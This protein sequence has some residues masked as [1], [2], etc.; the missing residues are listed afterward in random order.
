MKRM[1]S[2]LLA[3]LLVAVLAIP[4]FAAGNPGDLPY[5]VDNAGIL[6][7]DEE[8][9]LEKKAQS[10]S[11]KYACDVLILTVDSLGNSTPTAFA[12]DYF[13]YNGYGVGGDRSGIVLVLSMEERKCTLS[14]RGFA[15]DAFTDYGQD[16]MWDQILPEFGDDDYY[17]G[18]EVYLQLSDELLSQARAGEPLDVDTDSGVGGFAYVLCVIVGFLL[19]LIPMSVLKKQVKNVDSKFGA[20][21]YVT[22]EGL[23]LSQKTDRFL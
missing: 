23:Q 19:A 6:S 14:A 18:F 1:C 11:E 10:I 2:V 17:G 4:G 5:V 21:D 9:T 22:A 13:D 12:D 15:V 3:L 7:W 8:E 16:Y 20:G